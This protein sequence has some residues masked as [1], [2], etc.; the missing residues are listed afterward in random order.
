LS[1]LAT[2]YANFDQA[3][4]SRISV[5]L[6]SRQASTRSGSG[7]PGKPWALLALESDIEEES[8][9]CIELMGLKRAAGTAGDVRKLLV[10]LYHSIATRGCVN[11]FL[12]RDLDR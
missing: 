9:D 3:V 1:D 5:P 12:G 10:S 6:Q 4:G 2:G 7:T 8:L 11:S